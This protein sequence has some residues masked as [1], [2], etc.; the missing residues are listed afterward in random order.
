MQMLALLD[1]KLSSGETELL[2][3]ERFELP[4][5]TLQLLRGNNGCGK[6]LLLQAIHGEYSAWEGEILI[7]C[8]PA[9]ARKLI[10]LDKQLHLLPDE[11]VWQNLVIPLP[12]VTEHIKGKLAELCTVAGIADKLKWK[13]GY[14][15]YSAAKFVELIRAV[16]QLPYMILI[17][18]IDHDFDEANLK[19][20]LAICAH[21]AGAGGTVLAT[22]T[23]LLPGFGEVWDFAGGELRRADAL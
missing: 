7:K 16:V 23:R 6:S 15:S 2:R 11:S 8:E 20:A 21:A 1:F 5:G 17:D 10:L 12:R 19:R 18:D 4:P 22:S 9:A 13:A 3:C 14:L